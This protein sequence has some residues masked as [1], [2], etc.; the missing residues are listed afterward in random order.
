MSNTEHFQP[1]FLQIVIFIISFFLLSSWITQ[2]LNLELLTHRSLGLFCFNL[3]LSDFQIGLFLLICLHVYHFSPLTPPLWGYTHPDRLQL[4]CF[5][6]LIFFSFFF[7]V[8]SFFCLDFSWNY[9]STE[10]WG[11]CSS[12]GVLTPVDST[13]LQVVAATIGLHGI[14]H[15]K[16]RKDRENQRKKI[17]AC[18]SFR[19]PFF[20]WLSEI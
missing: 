17:S 2:I 6:A 7:F 12:F 15:S 20:L 10:W 18:E 1:L 3:F 16:Q 13:L 9:S 19:I 14:G 4:F 5:Q 8:S 11:K